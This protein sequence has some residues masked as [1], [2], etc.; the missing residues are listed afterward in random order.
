MEEIWKDI[1]DYEGLYQVSNLGRVKSMLRKVPHLCG[2]RTIPERIIKASVSSTTGYMIISL[3]KNS[4]YKLYL[5]HR[6]VAEAFIPNP[7]KLPY[8]NHKNEIRIDNR[9]D[10]LEWCTP[11]YNI[12]YSHVREKSISKIS[13][14]L[15]NMI[16]MAI[17]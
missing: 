15:N 10:N 4:T 2:Y 5:V 9:A 6:L 12:E 14:Q 7:D 11:N 13:I 16:M 1:E 3:C 17:S 8:V